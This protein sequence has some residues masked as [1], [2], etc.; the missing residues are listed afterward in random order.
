MLDHTTRCRF[1]GFPTGRSIAGLEQ[2]RGWARHAGWRSGPRGFTLVELLVV[3]AIIALLIAMLLP[4]LQSAREQAQRVKCAA[5]QRQVLL[6]ATMYGQDHR[7]KLPPTDGSWLH[8]VK[9]GPHK[10]K[11]IGRFISEEY[12]PPSEASVETLLH[13]PSAEIPNPGLMSVDRL[14]DRLVVNPGNGSQCRATYVGKFCTFV[15]YNTTSR[16]TQAD[17]YLPGYGA[18]ENNQGIR[19]SADVIS[20]IL[21]ADWVQN[22]NDLNSEAHLGGLNAGLHD[23]SVQYITWDNIDAIQPTH[24]LHP[25][26]NTHPYANLWHWAMEEF[27]RRN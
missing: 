19:Q 17:L 3:V 9:N 8:R 22:P 14:Y 15:G 20:P 18:P 4:A 1:F 21:V 26:S 2:G 23:G 27:G 25:Y 24:F 5:N 10:I 16:P 13:C 6:T 7:G 12:V 11:G